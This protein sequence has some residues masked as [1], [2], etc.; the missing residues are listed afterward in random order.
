MDESR[1]DERGV[2][3]HYKGDSGLAWEAKNP[4]DKPSVNQ[5]FLVKKKEDK[6]YMVSRRLLELTLRCC[7]CQVRL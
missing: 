2:K 1:D 5:E 3:G 4:I 7:W 6:L